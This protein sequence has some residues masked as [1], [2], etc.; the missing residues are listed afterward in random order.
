VSVKLPAAGTGEAGAVFAVVAEEVR[1]LAMGAAEAATNTSGLIEGA[2][3]KIR[4]GT[5]LVGTASEAF[6]QAT[7][8]AATAGDLVGGISPGFQ[9]ADTGNRAGQRGG[10][11]HGGVTQ[12][13]AASAE[14]SASASEELNTQAQEMTA[15]VKEPAEIVGGGLDRNQTIR[16]GRP[17]SR[18]RFRPAAF[19][20][21][22]SPSA[23]P[24]PSVF[25]TRAAGIASSG[26]RFRLLIPPIA[27]T[28]R[29]HGGFPCR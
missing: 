20:R 19:P 5:E 4:D 12:Q 14:D 29:A 28:R 24:T 18:R 6:T 13:N 27:A 15:L 8:S 7:R 11:P 21:P 22:K 23:V 17:A 10:A 3:K 26:D 16:K 2:V 9:G 1:S 25:R